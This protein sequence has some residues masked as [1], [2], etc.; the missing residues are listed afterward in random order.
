MT[1]SGATPTRRVDSRPKRVAPRPTGC[2]YRAPLN[3]RVRFRLAEAQLGTFS[4]APAACC[5]SQPF[6]EAH[7]AH[8]RATAVSRRR[9]GDG[10]L[11]TCRVNCVVVVFA[12][13]FGCLLIMHNDPTSHNW[14]QTLESVRPQ[15]STPRD[16]LG[17]VC[18][19]WVAL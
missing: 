10:R 9:R 17:L 5:H 8:S 14:T 12:S 19:L 16:R 15:V 1:T 11:S 2:V 3:A 6:G 4:R 18:A 13:L 7:R